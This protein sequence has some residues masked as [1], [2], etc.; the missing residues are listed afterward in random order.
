MAASTFLFAPLAGGIAPFNRSNRNAQQGQSQHS[1]RA[2]TTLNR[3]DHN[4]QQRGL[5]HSTGDRYINS[6]GDT[7][8]VM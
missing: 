5:Q 1:T 8:M 7:Y 3:G 2:I 6:T 4:T